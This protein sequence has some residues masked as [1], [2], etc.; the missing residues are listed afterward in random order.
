VDWKLRG[1]DDAMSD[2]M[3]MFDMSWD[4]EW[5]GIRSYTVKLNIDPGG[6]GVLGS[7]FRAES[8]SYPSPISRNPK[9]MSQ[10]LPTQD[11]LKDRRGKEANIPQDP[12]PQASNSTRIQHVQSIYKTRNQHKQSTHKPREAHLIVLFFVFTLAITSSSNCSSSLF[13]QALVDRSLD[14]RNLI[15]SSVD[16]VLAIA[17]SPALFSSSRNLASSHDSCSCSP[18]Y[19]SQRLTLCSFDSKTDLQPKKDEDGDPLRL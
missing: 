4:L 9:Q 8:T 5:H 11:Y 3:M 6:G 1:E 18:S 17:A 10:N 16:R 14:S 13:V 2:G 7:A 19:A 12:N 15:S